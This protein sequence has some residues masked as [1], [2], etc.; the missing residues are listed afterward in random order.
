MAHNNNEQPANLNTYQPGQPGQAGDTGVSDDAASFVP[1]VLARLGLSQSVPS[2]AESEKQGLNAPHRPAWLVRLEAIQHMEILTESAQL[3]A[4]LHTL[5]D[6]HEN[7]RVAT[8]RALGSLAS[9]EAVEALAGALRDPAWTVRAAAVLA[10]GKQKGQV[11]PGPLVAALRD[12]DATVRASAASAL[13]MLGEQAPLSPLISAL[14]DSS[15]I[16]RESAVLA[17]GEIGEL[18][19]RVPAA[20]FLSARSDKDESVRQAAE[21][22]LQRLYPELLASDPAYT[23]SPMTEQ[24]AS[25]RQQGKL[26]GHSNPSPEIIRPGK[27]KQ[28]QQAARRPAPVGKRLFPRVAAI[29]AA[30]LLLLSAM[31]SWLAVSHRP[32]SAPAGRAPVFATSGISSY[33]AVGGPAYRIAWSPKGTAIASTNAFGLIQVRDVASGRVISTF[34]GDF[35][36]V[37]SLGWMPDNALLVAAQATNGTVQVWDVL[38]DRPILITPPLSGKASTATWSPDGSQV[39]FDGGDATVQVWN[40]ITDAKVVTYRGHSGS[41]NALSWSPDG[42]EIAS[43]SDDQTVQV[44]NAA[45]G[46]EDWPSFVHTDAVSVVAWSP[47]NTRCA[48]ATA[49]G[50]VEVWDD[51]SWNKVQIAPAIAEWPALNPPLV[52]FI[53]WSPDAAHLAFATP[54]GSLQIWDASTNQLLY[55]YPNRNGQVNNVAWSPDGTHIASANADG[56]VQILPVPNATTVNERL[57]H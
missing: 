56:T 5:R 38:T 52:S 57:P 21:L 17:L 39:A 30:A 23:R 47:D 2:P 51:P 53:A 35:L 19:T 22:V 46:T 4:L 9:Q 16:V 26:N 7:V 24:E 20:L 29:A 15:W 27:V 32:Q 13:A 34:T 18:G 55:T 45:T 36:K 12:E 31:F 8:A 10:L 44:W 6:E 28:P 42:T 37:L 50:A 11:P 48:V 14:Y 54:G 40:L 49:N 43:A 1:A 3:P 41:I 25:V 33:H